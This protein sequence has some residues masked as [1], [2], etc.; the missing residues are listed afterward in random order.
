MAVKQATT[1]P[2]EVGNPEWLVYVVGMGEEPRMRE[3]KAAPTGEVTYS[4]GCIMRVMRKDG[5]KADKTASINVIHAESEYEL[6]QIYRSEGR[7]Y[8]Q[9]YMSGSGESSRLA[10]S[11][12][13]E[14]LVPADAPPSQSS[15]APAGS[16][17]ADGKA[18]A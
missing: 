1:F 12:T 18:V 9:P 10:Y 2:V 11:I 17:A 15:K 5:P 16:G 8:V 13:C 6:G 4:T 3:G 14:R 7:V